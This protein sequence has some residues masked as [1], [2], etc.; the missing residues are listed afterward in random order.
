MLA[1]VSR[2]TPHCPVHIHI[3]EQ[4]K[5]VDDC[6]AWSGARPVAWLFDNFDVSQRWC[7]VHATHMDDSETSRLAQ[8]GAVAGLCP[9]T[10]ANLG[11]GFFP[12]RDYH[13][14]GG[15]WGIGSDSHI[16][17]SVSDELRTYEYGQ[18]LLH[19]KRNVLNGVEGRSTGAALFGAAVSGGAQALGRSTG[20]L[21]PGYRAD[22]AVLDTNLPAFA[23]RAG[24]Q[25][26]DAWIFASQEGVVRDVI[27]GGRH[28]LQNRHHAGERQIA[29]AFKSSMMKLLA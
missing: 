2:R 7:L 13:D 10:E 8:S 14:A 5:E 12:A 3:A 21:A 15:A 9:T 22:I 6:V 19:R 27:C 23:G 1:E 4:T 11:D 17:V 18:R 29:D 16:A 24:D 28:V 25:L 20:V 26:L